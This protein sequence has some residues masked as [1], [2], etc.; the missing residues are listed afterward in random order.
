MFAHVK[1][2]EECPELAAQ[3]IAFNFY[4]QNVN[5]GYSFIQQIFFESMLQVKSFDQHW[6]CT[7]EQKHPQEAYILV[8]INDIEI[9]KINMQSK[10]I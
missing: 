8:N 10:V 4:N 7:D 1:H 3:D 2:L 5:S 6:G 9:K